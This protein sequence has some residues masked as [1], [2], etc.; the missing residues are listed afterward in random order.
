MRPEGA[1]S[2]KAMK[3]ESRAARPKRRWAILG[4]IHANIDALDAVLAD[5]REGGATDYL[6]VGDVVGYNAAPR[7]CI[8][9]LIELDCATVRGNH[10]H[11]TAFSEDLEGFHP[12][13]ADVIQWTRRQLGPEHMD[14]L[15]KLEYTLPIEHF[16]LVHSTLDMPDMW[17][18][19]FDKMEA[20]ANF[21]CQK[22]ALCFFGHT[23]VPL[24]FERAAEVVGGLYER[25]HVA[26]GRKY[27]INVGSVGQPRDGDPRAAYVVYDMASNQIELRRIAYDI[28]AAQQRIHTAGLPERLAQRLA[29]GR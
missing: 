24:A 14:F 27:F 20:E 16:T 26:L 25:I 12:L 5:A 29:S 13:A 10:D 9:R 11:Y 18:Y 23:H 19:V 17:G 3:N 1:S 8:E 7:E 2:E 6:S 28:E 4:D 22:R 21:N 15:K